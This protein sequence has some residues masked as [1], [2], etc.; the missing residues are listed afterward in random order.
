MHIF[1]AS[2]RGT[3]CVLADFGILG[4]R[5]VCVDFGQMKEHPV[6]THDLRYAWKV[7]TA[8]FNWRLDRIGQRVLW[9]HR[10]LWSH[11][12]T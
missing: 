7:L 2:H 12:F 3:E 6:R 5:V 10:R 11:P 8:D 9:Q 4:D 1:S